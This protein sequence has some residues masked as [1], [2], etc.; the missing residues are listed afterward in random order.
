MQW[1]FWH[2]LLRCQHCSS[3]WGPVAG[4]TNHRA[5]WA[6]PLGTAG[7]FDSPQLLC[8]TLNIK[9]SLLVAQTPLFS[10]RWVCTS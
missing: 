3:V 6:E 10:F 9:I 8:A 2:V 7:V 1:R 4:A 5:P